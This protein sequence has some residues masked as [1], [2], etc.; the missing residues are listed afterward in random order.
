MGSERIFEYTVIGDHVNLASRLE[1][2][3]KY[4][5]VKIVTS[6]FT[7]DEIQ[8]GGSQIP[9]HRVLDFVKVKGKKQAIE[10]I[11]VICDDLPVDGLKCFAEARQLYSQ[12]KWD[13]AISA[14]G[15]ANQYFKDS[16]GGAEDTPS[17]LYMERCQE[18][19][20]NPPTSEWDGSWEMQSK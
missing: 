18:F 6:R 5:G 11:E 17:I 16:L 13:E 1:G 7:F 2:L 12:R 3:T 8:K 10:L 19:K 20:T 4:Y 9:A 15:K 14:F